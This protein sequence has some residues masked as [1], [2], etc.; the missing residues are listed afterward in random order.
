MFRS[1]SPEQ[2][3][4]GWEIPVM[5]K[6]INRSISFEPWL[7]EAIDRR[8]TELMMQRSDY[9]RRCVLKDLEHAGEFI[10]QPTALSPTGSG[11]S[12]RAAGE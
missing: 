12:R 3:W 9:I 2:L 8:R 6:V 7:L 5:R 11:P 4:P 1:C 10:I